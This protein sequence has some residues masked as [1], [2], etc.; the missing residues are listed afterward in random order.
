[1]DGVAVGVSPPGFG[2]VARLALVACLAAA[3]A[4]AG[5]ISMTVGVR[6]EMRD[7]ELVAQVVAANQGDE[8]AQAV[9]PTLRFRGQEVRG[10]TK[11][12][13]GP[14][15]SVETEITVPAAGLGTGH[16]PLEV[17]VDYA[18]A[19]QYP[20]QALNVVPVVVGEPPPGKL[21]VTAIEDTELAGS[22]SIAVTVKNLAGAARKAVVRVIAP[23]G[24]EA[25]EAPELDLGPWEE[26]ALSVP[27]KNRTARSGSSLPLFVTVE[28]EDG[29]VHQTAISSGAL[30]IVDEQPLFAGMG[31]AAWIVAGVLLA[32]WLLAIV[33]LRG[34]RAAE[35]RS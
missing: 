21:V 1:M 30:K 32:G 16:W 8:A 15:E 20:F 2:R 29:G 22:G 19:N 17:V 31:R 24:V 33:W 7:G 25:G 4:A 10:A 34:R 13:L 5:T 28:H 9:T 11:P 23:E 18:D 27:V 12:S 6:A 3:P 14:Q 35:G 26:R